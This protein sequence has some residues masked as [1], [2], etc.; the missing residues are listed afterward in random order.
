MQD[1]HGK[2]AE[3]HE[4]FSFPNYSDPIKVTMAYYL[5]CNKRNRRYLLSYLN[6]RLEKIRRLRWEAGAVLPERIQHDTISSRENDYFINYSKIVGEYMTNIDLDLTSDVEPP[7]EL[8][9][10]IRVKKSCGE[11]MTENGPIKLDKGS[12]HFLKRSDV[13]H[14]IR[15]G[16]IEHVQSDEF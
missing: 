14:L 5:E 11:I 3:I 13:E 10:E 16:V 8:L 7:K 9:I 12:T 4:R 6:H 2:I 15:Q 1:I